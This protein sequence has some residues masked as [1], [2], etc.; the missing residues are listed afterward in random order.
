MQRKIQPLN[1]VAAAIA[2]SF[3]LLLLGIS[4]SKQPESTTVET[5]LPYE[6]ITAEQVV[7]QES[8]TGSGRLTWETEYRLSFK[9]GGI[10]KAINI[11]E[12]KRVQAGQILAQLSTDEINTR[13]QQAEN[14]VE[15]SQRDL[16]RV[17]NL[18]ADS[19]A[20]LEQLQNAQTQLTHAL[21]DLDY[22]RVAGNNTRIVA[23]AS[24]IIQKILLKENEATGAG[25]PVFLFASER[26]GKILVLNVTDT[27]VVKIAEGDKSELRFDAW[28]DQMFVGQVSEISTLA[29]PTTGMYAVKIS[30]E[31]ADNQLKA[32]FIGRAAITASTRLNL[33]SIPAQ[34]LAEAYG[35][36]GYVFMVRNKKAMKQPVTIFSISGENILLSDG[37][38]PGDKIVTQG[39][40]RF[41]GDTINLP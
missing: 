24:G 19:V 2:T 36:Q 6:S 32:G 13:L 10:I 30:V 40:H 12:G 14:A 22:A 31:D 7:H 28:R 11:Q 29:E 4:C 18:F 17:K 35:N 15:K 23:P 39:Y 3:L 33:T 25:T 26:A 41:K 38:L 34:A 21:L 8:I 5:S 20:T 16:Q 37:V 9:T 1:S 27:E